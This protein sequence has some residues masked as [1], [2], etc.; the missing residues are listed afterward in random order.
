MRSIDEQLRR[1]FGG[2]LSL[3]IYHSGQL[4]SEKDTLELAR[5]GALG[6]ARVHSS[7]LNDAVPATRILSLPYVFDSVEHMRR[8]FDGAFGAEILAACEERGLVGL[9]LYDSGSRSFYNTRR[10][11]ETPADLHGLKLR[12]PQSDIFIE[13]VAA[14]GASP[15]PLA[16]GNVFGSLQTR[17]IDGAENNMPSYYTSRHFE[18]AR[19]WSE[20]E[21]SYAPDVLLMSKRV[22]DALPTEQRDFV[23]AAARD[24]LPLMRARWDE[25]VEKSRAAVRAAGIEIRAVD[26]DAFR[27]AVRPLLDRYLRDPEIERLHGMLR[28][29]A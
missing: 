27:G 25:L 10:P 14:L 20:S 2:A 6:V 21:H 29:A 3:R 16:Y 11:V 24:S 23:L 12:V 1:R 4:G 5:I 17:L 26:R 22:A 19:Y 8:A 15:T 13:S 9:A 28:D 18:I 7:V